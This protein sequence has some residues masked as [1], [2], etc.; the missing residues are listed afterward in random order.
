[1]DNSENNYRACPLCAEPIRTAAVKCRHCG[2]D[3]RDEAVDE[4]LGRAQPAGEVE[5]SSP[6]VSSPPTPTPL[7][8]A[9]G[10]ARM[11][12]GL[13]GHWVTL[14]ALGYM[15][16]FFIF[17][18]SMTSKASDPPPSSTTVKLF[19]SI[20][21]VLGGAGYVLIGIGWTAAVRVATRHALGCAV[22]SFLHTL[23]AIICIIGIAL[24]KF[25]KSQE[26]DLSWVLMLLVAANGLYM[27]SLA[28]WYWAAGLALLNKTGQGGLRT[29]LNHVGYPILATVT[30]LMAFPAVLASNSKVQFLFVLISMFTTIFCWMGVWRHFYVFRNRLEALNS[31]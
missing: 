27:L 17:A 31:D 26:P 30:G 20:F 24:T 29:T 21:F 19:I 4:F 8:T 5:S 3:V 23:V 1:M 7:P 6:I 25:G 9:N 15:L 14:S 16:I 18:L 12:T 2:S 22:T 13:V 10:V 11:T 28:Y